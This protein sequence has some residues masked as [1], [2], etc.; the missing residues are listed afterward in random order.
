MLEL[1]SSPT[2]S[3]ASASTT[4]ALRELPRKLAHIQS[5]WQ[6]LLFVKWEPQILG[7][8]RRLVQEIVATAK[9]GNL[10]DLLQPARR[11]EQ[12]L[13]LLQ[14][15]PTAPPEVERSQV[16]GI[17][18]NLARAILASQ[19][20][21]HVAPATSAQ[22]S[23]S[24]QLAKGDQQ[25][26]VYVLEPESHA[27]Q[28]LAQ[29][30]SHYGFAVN[31]FASTE[32]LRL[33]MQRQLPDI[34][35]ADT[36]L[37][38]RSM[39][40]I[41]AMVELQAEFKSQIPVIFLSVRSDLAARLA[42]VRAGGLGYFSKPVD[43]QA[44]FRRVDD[45]L[46]RKAADYKVLIVED[47]EQL[48]SAYAL[49]LQHAGF[50]V[51][52]LTRPLQI[53]QILQQFQP[54]L[55]LMDMHLSGCTGIELMQLIRQEPAYYALPILFVSSETDPAKHN[56]ALS[57]GA[58]LFLLKPIKPEQLAAAVSHRVGR[59]RSIMRLM[60][61]LGQQD[62]LTGLLN[63]R[64]F[65]GYLEQ[66]LGEL[67]EGHKQAVLIYCEVDQYRA[68]RDRLGISTADLLL[69]DLAAH[70][71]AQLH[72]VSRLAHLSDACFCALL[73]DTDVV[74]ARDVASELCRSV[75]AAMYSAEKESV[76]MTL[77]VGVAPL[78]ER[79]LSG[80]AWLSDAAVVC[81]IAR[82]KGGNQVQV[83][84]EAETEMAARDQDRRCADLLRAALQDDAFYCVY[85]PIAGLR[86]KQLERY[87]VLLRVR[88]TQGREISA[89][90]ILE[91]ARGESL[92]ADLDRW[93]IRHVLKQVQ[94]RSESGLK[95]VFFI[96]I[97]AQSLND[98]EFFDW[99]EQS[100]H[101]SAVNPRQLVLEFMVADIST[102]LKTAAQTFEHL[103]HLG[104]AVALEHFGASLNAAQLLKHVTVD[105]VKLDAAFVRNLVQNP[106][107]RDS[108]RD[109][110][111]QASDSGIM[112]I[113][114]FVED[115]ASLAVLWQSG[116][117]FIQGNFLQEPDAVLDYDFSATSSD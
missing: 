98:P 55:L 34:I 97:S 63:Q 45:L 38:Q 115:A 75:A 72:Y 95:T 36:Q 85:Q 102:S 51:Q 41:A 112:V 69:A 54:D 59:A 111:Q 101:E 42:A 31:W 106:A 84:R 28:L 67:R 91:V 89:A 110:L 99:F 49:V 82:E 90:R 12:Q 73:I 74:T 70:V 58:D 9:T 30:L 8:I 10:V 3:S 87:E 21:D 14:H 76:A 18:Q 96:K 116:V 32:E 88:D 109:L 66:H 86:G 53:L 60:H 15:H 24:T 64:A 40:G 37:G 2:T 5:L 94:A 77:S 52:I 11:L 35:L 104:C 29:Q 103:H 39:V 100:L 65:L 81:D 6:K 107:N 7:L 83:H 50:S 93:V 117:H 71:K 19:A 61:F 80:Q 4:S 16:K 22:S 108:V 92:V 23:V 78:D 68:L 33:A 56:E 1:D 79:Y 25:H 46:Q 105:Y 43:C 114:G 62:P 113:A 47:E 26:Y 17:L 27:A 20:S 13:E 44:L 48:A 57:Q